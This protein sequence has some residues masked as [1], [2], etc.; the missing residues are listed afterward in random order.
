M[1]VTL[2]VILPVTPA[3][4][5]TA[6]VKVDVPSTVSVPSIFRLLSK[7]TALW[8]FNVPTITVLP[9][10]VSTVNLSSPAWFS[11]VNVLLSALMVTLSW[12]VAAPSTFKVELKSEAPV[13]SNVLSSVVAPVTS[14]VPAISILVSNLAEVT[15]SST[16]L[17]VTTL[18]CAPAKT[19]SKLLFK[20]VALIEDPAANIALRLSTS[21]YLYILIVLPAVGALPEVNWISV[22]VGNVYL[23]DWS[24]ITLS[25]VTSISD[26]LKYGNVNEYLWVAEA[27]A[28][29]SIWGFSAF[30]FNI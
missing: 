26:S 24:W 5:E 21:V 10:S 1:P 25:T 6:P 16:I 20:S 22:A 9:L 13:T 8:A 4:A 28:E 3:G 14:N 30:S 2:P 11:I 7:S 12:N 23:V 27:F 17:L 19:R 15:A 18:S 29:Y